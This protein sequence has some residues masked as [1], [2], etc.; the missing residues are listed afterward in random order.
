MSETVASP[1]IIPSSG[2]AS[3]RGSGRGRGQSG[4]RGRG[5]QHGSRVTTTPRFRPTFKGNTEE[6]NG[7][8]FQCFNECEDK[9][10]FLKTVEA[11][12]EYIAKKR[13]YP[14]NMVSLTKDFV[15]PE[16]LKPTELE[17]SETNRLVIA[18]WEKKVSAYCTRAD[19]LDSNLKTAYAV[20]WGQCSEAMAKITSLDDFEAKRHESDCVW[21]L[22]EIKGITY[23]F[24][25][26]RYIYLSLD[27]ARTS[28][29]TYTQG[30]ED[31]ISSYLEHFRSLVEV[32]EHYGDAIGEDPGLLDATAAVSSD[33]D[34]ATK[35]LKIARDCTLALAFLKRADCRRFGTLRADLENEFSRRN[36][37]YPINLTA[38]FSLL[39]NFKP[40]KR[41][42]PRRNT[43]SQE[44][45]VEEEDG[46]TFVQS[47]AVIPGAD[48]VTHTG[49]TCFRCEYKGHYADKCPNGLNATLLQV[50]AANAVTLLQASH[51]KAIVADD[52]N[53]NHEVSNF[54]FT[55]RHDLIPSSWVLL[56]S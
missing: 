50:E 1:P 24:E 10:H 21:I 22:K 12:G 4:S 41:E 9:K 28:Y 3:G 6:M 20:I 5:N 16:I 43:R 18:I 38:A 51:T 54:T 33:T 36:D 31:S 30:A 45:A 14:G 25:G 44:A 56:D 34:D 32:L 47:G 17:V 39:V 11:L 8:V 53:A 49:V 48:G 29:Y 26:Q 15:K 46:M 27:N 2:T 13:K 23:R 42:E 52:N 37:Q 19:Y 7:H 40:P 55:P 35:R